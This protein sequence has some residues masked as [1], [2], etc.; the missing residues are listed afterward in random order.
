MVIEHR[1]DPLLPLGVLLD[2]RVTQ[3]D[4]GAQI[5][6]VIGRDPRLRQPPGQQQLAVMA[7]V[8]A[9]GFRA[10]L[11]PAPRRGLRR[12]GEMHHSADRPKLLDEEPPAGR[13]LER[14]L[15][16]LASEPLKEP[17]HPGTIRRPNPRTADLAADQDRSTQQ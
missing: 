16:L 9:V 3:P 4:L 2:Q 8:R 13:R 5:E 6:D 11:V 12:L 15:Q 1:L 10:L 7:S 14:D 17:A